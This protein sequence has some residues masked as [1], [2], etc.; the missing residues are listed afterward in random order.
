MKKFLEMIGAVVLLG[1]TAAYFLMPS[2]GEAASVSCS[3]TLAE[4]RARTQVRNELKAP[5]TAKFGDRTVTQYAD[6]KFKIN[7]MVTAQ[8]SFGAMI[9]TNYS[10]IVSG[11]H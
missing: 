8:N 6:C 5:D 7:G 11:K 1:G 2:S 3:P 10:V 9:A 4:A